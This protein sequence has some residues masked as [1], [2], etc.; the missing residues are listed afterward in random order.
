MG[1][2]QRQLVGLAVA[3][4]EKGH[5]VD[6]LVYHQ[7]N[8][9][10]ET[11]DKYVI[12]VTLIQERN[13]LKRLL[14]MRRFIR[15]GRYDAVI[16]FLEAAGFIAEMAGLPRRKWKLIVGERSANPRIIESFKLR[17]YRW[18][19]IFADYI[20]ANSHANLAL[21]RKINPLLPEK[22]CKVIYNLL[23][24]EIWKP[25]DS[26]LPLQDG[27]LRLIVAS[28]HQYLKNATGLIEAVHNL[29]QHE[30][31]KL[32]IEWYGDK[33]SDDSFKDA[34]M[35][36]KRY[37]LENIFSFYPATKNIRE[38]MQQAD[39]VGLFSF[40][41]GLPNAVCEAMM[42]GKPVISSSVSEITLIFKDNKELI[43]DPNN[44]DEIIRVLKNVLLLPQKELL[45]LG[46]MNY[47]RAKKLFFKE[48]IIQEYLSILR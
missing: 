34:L 16:A 19:H 14:K 41:G 30:K 15:K 12:P 20:V 40:Y 1:G 31:N 2:A 42:L 5:D 43:F 48:K 21:V 10:K 26:Y 32:Q 8:F 17:W 7:E 37:G 4:K 13:Y 33:S 45:N 25:A 11:L 3:F 29:H 27:K 47:F 46:Q 6:F 38:K 24:P 18:C 44:K 23:D 22:K 28:S 9:F 36:V 35:K 39:V